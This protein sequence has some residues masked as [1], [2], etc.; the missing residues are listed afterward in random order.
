MFV[1]WYDDF[2]GKVLRQDGGY[3]VS[4]LT[5]QYFE[6]LINGPYNNLNGFDLYVPTIN[7]SNSN[8]L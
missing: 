5:I 3:D 2:G 8:P 6:S 4:G 1:Y 7:I